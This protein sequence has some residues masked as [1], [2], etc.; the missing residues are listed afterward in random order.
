MAPKD[1]KELEDMLEFAVKINKCKFPPVVLSV[2]RTFGRNRRAGRTRL[3][4]SGRLR[5]V[6]PCRAGQCEY[7]PGARWLIGFAFGIGLDRFAMLRY[8]DRTTAPV[9]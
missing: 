7:R 8:G 5:H 2:Y 1:F 4:G 3:A 6:P 9:L